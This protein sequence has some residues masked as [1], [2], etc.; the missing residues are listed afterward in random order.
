[1]VITNATDSMVLDNGLVGYYAVSKVTAQVFD[2]A[3]D[4]V[5]GPRVEWHCRGSFGL[6]IA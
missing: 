4:E 2:V 6:R 5:M 1:M 3:D